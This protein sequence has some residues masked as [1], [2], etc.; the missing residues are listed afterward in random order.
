MMR[1][2]L[3]STNSIEHPQYSD[4]K[5]HSAR[6]WYSQSSVA[7]IIRQQLLDHM[8]ESMVYSKADLGPFQERLAEL[9]QIV[10]NDAANHPPAMIQLLE[11]KI[12]QGGM[13]ILG[14]A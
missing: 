5:H 12:A 14:L 3:L 2:I 13:Y 6:L 4:C 11:R 10:Q 1:D 7:D 8:R 9:Q